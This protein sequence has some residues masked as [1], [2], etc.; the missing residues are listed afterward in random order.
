VPTPNSE[1]SGITAGPNGTFWFTEE[2]GNKIGEINASTHAITEFS[3]PT[4]DSYPV[5]IAPDSAGN[6]WFTEASGANIGEINATTGAISEFPV[7]FNSSPSGIV[8]S[9]TGRVWFTESNGNNIGEA[10]PSASS[11]LAGLPAATAG[12]LLPVSAPG[13][14]EVVWAGPSLFS[15]IRQA[16]GAPQAHGKVLGHG[17]HPVA[18]DL[19]AAPDDAVWSSTDP[20]AA[21]AFGE[22][23][24]D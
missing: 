13:P 7:T 19:T 6:L 22:V 24:L 23:R 21:T 16:G 18:G 1:P 2:P 3:I 5:G 11:A 10:I 15:P 4:F 8:V 14:R 9:A 20:A 12:R 17:I